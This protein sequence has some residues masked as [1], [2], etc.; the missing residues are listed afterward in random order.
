[1]FSCSSVRMKP[2][3]EKMDFV[4]EDEDEGV[5]LEVPQIYYEGANNVDDEDPCLSWMTDSVVV[6]RGKRILKYTES[7]TYEVQLKDEKGESSWCNGSIA[8]IQGVDIDG[9]DD[10]RVSKEYWVE[11]YDLE[12]FEKKK[13]RVSLENISAMDKC[14]FYNI[15]S[16]L[17]DEAAN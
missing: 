6:V 13:Y 11:E 3:K 9:C 4:C 15:K 2:E 5:S 10:I 7:N 16:F 8:A 14:D 17:N 12:K 1:M